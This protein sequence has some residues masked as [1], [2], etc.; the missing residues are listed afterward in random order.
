MSKVWI[1]G[2]LLSEGTLFV[3]VGGRT[4]DPTIVQFQERDVV[5]FHVVDSSDGD[6]ARGDWPGDWQGVVR[7]LL[8]WSTQFTPAGPQA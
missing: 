3:T 2:N 5:A 1:P 4:M 6:A 8:Q 7:P